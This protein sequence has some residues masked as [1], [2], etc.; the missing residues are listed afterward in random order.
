MLKKAFNSFCDSHQHLQQYSQTLR[1]FNEKNIRKS[2]KKRNISLRNEKICVNLTLRH[3][4]A[5]QYLNY[6]I[7]FQFTGNNNLFSRKMKPGHLFNI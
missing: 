3:K 5:Q 2:D 4:A 7:R 1:R 6:S